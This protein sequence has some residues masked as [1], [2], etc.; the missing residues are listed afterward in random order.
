MM[1]NESKDLPVGSEGSTSRSLLGD[2]RRDRPAAWDRL[3]RLYAPLV[4]T[5]CHRWR[6]ADQDV[7]DVLQ[8]VFAAVARNLGS[9]RLEQP[10]DS[11]R[12]WLATIARNKMRDYFRRQ[13]NQPCGVG[14][15][16]ANLRLAQ[17][18]DC[19]AFDDDRDSDMAG[20]GNVL[21]TALESIRAEFHE[22]TWQAFWCV[23]VEGRAAADVA[24]DLAMQPGA[25][26]VC[27]SRV[28]SRLRR[29]LELGEE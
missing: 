9:F 24:V 13:S 19:E 4:A 25:V 28:L 6:I 11:F 18:P 8:D 27:K 3:V 12:G 21:N 22:R 1:T 10:N 7:A 29:E 26:R 15:T 2:A 23:V 14:G 17:H 5:W 20:F 16:E